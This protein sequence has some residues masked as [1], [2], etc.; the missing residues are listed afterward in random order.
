M[1]KTN[2]KQ[3]TQVKQAF[4]KTAIQAIFLILAVS[5]T[6][7]MDGSLSLLAAAQVQAVVDRTGVALGESIQLSVTLEGGDGEPD[8]SVIKMF[9]VISK[10]SSTSYQFING[11]SSHQKNYNFV[12]LPLREGE[13]TIPAIPV[14]ID[15]K[16]YTTRPITIQVQKRGT[17]EDSQDLFLKV[18]VSNRTPYV[19]EQIT[20]TFTLSN[21][22]QISDAH[23]AKPD[24]EGFTA[25][26]LDN[27]SSQSTIINGREY[28][29]RALTYILIPLKSGSLTIDPAEIQLNVIRRSQRRRSLSPFDDFWGRNEVE[30]RFLQTE[31]LTLTVKPLP[32]VPPSQKFSGLVGTFNLS[33]RIEKTDLTVGDSVTHTLT[34]SGNGNILDA[35]DLRPAAPD[36]FKQYAD[37]PQEEVQLTAAGYHGKK[38]FKTA[39][40]PVTAGE[41][42]LPELTLTYF[43]VAGKT[44]RTLSTPPIALVVAPSQT[45]DASDSKAPAAPTA[46]SKSEVVFTGRDILPLKEDL[47]ALENQT[48]FSLSAFIVWLLIPAA[49]YG[50]A[51]F[52]S[53]YLR[54]EESRQKHQARLA[55]KALKAAAKADMNDPAYLSFLY[56]ALVAAIR[57]KSGTAGES[58]T[59]AETEALLLQSGCDGE[60]ARKAA[61]L[62]EEIESANYSGGRAGRN[63]RQALLAKT[64]SMAGRLLK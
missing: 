62:L 12:L 18:D 36:A 48:A 16:V 8:I 53:D 15:G 42:E 22:I 46:K 13:L 2:L 43:D 28:I 14:K 17:A 37:S 23:F 64:T 49:G 51:K 50:A 61:Q 54:K 1:A 6:L 26:E 20:C 10:G 55:R 57:A 30:P 40:V 19:G 59:W 27:Q 11:R 33:A 5:L 31:P 44:Y 21:A 47:T 7:V 35:P 25:K 32:E 38:I 34:L 63:D 3:K 9:K 29:Q 41:Y 56:R 58:L 4:S 39:L 45:A 24:F 52:L 60:T